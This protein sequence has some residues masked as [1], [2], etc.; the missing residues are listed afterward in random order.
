GPTIP[1]ESVYV[2]IARVVAEGMRTVLRV[3][4]YSLHETARFELAMHLAADFADTEETEQGE[5]RQTAP[6]EA[7]WHAERQ[8]VVFRYRHPDLDRA[9]AVRVDRSPATVRFEGGALVFSLAVAP[10]RPVELHL[11][12]EPIFD[13]ARRPAPPATFD[14][15]AT[16]L[17]R[18]RQG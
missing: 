4:N 3:E 15:T 9:V 1:K 18:V 11:A 12:A 7:A 5:R 6:V 14:E 17:G 2:E 16:P 10:H 8:E 13:G